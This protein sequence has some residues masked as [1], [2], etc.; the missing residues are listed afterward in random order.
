MFTYTRKDNLS[1]IQRDIICR[2]DGIEAGRFRIYEHG[3]FD[4]SIL[5]EDE[6]QG[7]GLAR[8]MIK[9]MLDAMRS[10]GAYNPLT[11]IYID[12]D[13]SA[14]FWNY[15]GMHANP[16]EDDLTCSEYGYEKRIS[17]EA[18]GNF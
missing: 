11:F 9:A 13:A 15:L 7:R 17:M 4:M 8:G 18:L 10:E 6:F 1:G 12:S 3:I 5:I 14:G 2:I 16:N